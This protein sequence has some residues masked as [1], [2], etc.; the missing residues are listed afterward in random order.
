MLGMLLLVLIASLSFAEGH[1]DEALTI[2][3]L[4]DNG[5]VAMLF[6]FTLEWDSDETGTLPLLILP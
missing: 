3:P 4:A 6:N 5:R 2:Y 1:F